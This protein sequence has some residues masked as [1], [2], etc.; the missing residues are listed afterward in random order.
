[1]GKNKI[2]YRFWLTRAVTGPYIFKWTV[3]YRVSAE[4]KKTTGSG[5]KDA[6]ALA[7][8]HG[9]FG[10]GG[11]PIVGHVDVPHQVSAEGELASGT[12]P[13]GLTQIAIKVERFGGSS[14]LHVNWPG[15]GCHP[16]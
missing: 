4:D 10:Y 15:D 3:H 7:Y 13:N 9:E 2:N 11:P 5:W 12:N 16:S 14:G 8:I 6:G 1:V